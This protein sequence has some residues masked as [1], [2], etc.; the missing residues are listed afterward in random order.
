MKETLLELV[1]N[2]DHF[3]TVSSIW[4]LS[5]LVFGVIS[6][7]FTL[8]YCFLSFQQKSNYTTQHSMLIISTTLI[9]T[10]NFILFHLSTKMINQFNQFCKT[11]TERLLNKQDLAL[12]RSN[13]AH[14]ATKRTQQYIESIQIELYQFEHYRVKLTPRVFY[15]LQLHVNEFVQMIVFCI[16]FAIILVQTE[17]N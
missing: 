15:I 2:L 9:S 8:L 16:N 10:L 5:K 1:T 14:R 17:D 12:E 4:V 13:N 7:V 6:L 3:Y 11:V